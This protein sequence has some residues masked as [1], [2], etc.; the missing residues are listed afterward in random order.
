MGSI[1]RVYV[2]D[3]GLGRSGATQVPS[4]GRQEGDYDDRFSCLS[5]VGWFRPNPFGLH[6]TC[7]NVWEWCRDLA[8]RYSIP[9]RPGDG[10]RELQA[11]SQTQT[12]FRGASFIN[13]ARFGRSADRNAL[14]AIVR[15]YD[16]GARPCRSVR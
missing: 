15:S 14:D 5:P 2:M 7:G 1:R 16:L 8:L 3:W 9:P 4:R 6:D 12:I 13:P 10:L 11:G